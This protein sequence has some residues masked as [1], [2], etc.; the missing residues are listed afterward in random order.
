MENRWGVLTGEE[1]KKEVQKGEIYI[2]PFNEDN[3][4]CNSY[5]YRLANRL[6]RISNMVLDLKSKD[7]YEEIIIEN[8]GTVLY[9]NECYLGATLEKVGSNNYI[10]LI[11]GR[12][13]VGRKFITNHVTSNII[14]QGFFG[15]IT[16]EI[17]VQKPTI[18]Y[19]D[20]LFGQIMWL[21]VVGKAKYYD[22]EYQNQE[23]ATIS[24]IYKEMR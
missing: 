2:S 18:V 7:I 8:K 19:P 17:T 1:I 11:T 6:I 4:S 12:S 13:S 5:N 24:N 22:G 9:P 14:E 3:I 20:I 23:V 16:L 21:T 15:H 10:G